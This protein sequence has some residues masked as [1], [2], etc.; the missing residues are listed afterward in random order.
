MYGLKGMAA[1]VHHAAI[2]GFSSG[3]IYDFMHKALAS[4]LT[5]FQ[6]ENLRPRSWKQEVWVEVLALLTRP[7][8]PPW[9]PR[10]HE[11]QYYRNNPHTYKRA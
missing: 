11:G 5:G 10:N 9:Q 1:Y 3:K 7:I 2:L 4:T 6:P 8:R